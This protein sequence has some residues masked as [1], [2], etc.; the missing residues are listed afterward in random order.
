VECNGNK[1]H[2]YVLHKNFVAVSFL[3]GRRRLAFVPRFELTK[4]K[5]KHLLSLETIVAN[6]GTQSLACKR[7]IEQ[8]KAGMPDGLSSN[9]NTNLGKF[10]RALQ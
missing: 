9:Q 6:V 7:A 10:W 8:L 3:G 1:K 2:N 4:K 5:R